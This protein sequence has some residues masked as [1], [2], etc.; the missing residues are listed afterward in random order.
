M[1]CAKLS[2]DWN[3]SFSLKCFFLVFFI[4]FGLHFPTPLGTRFPG[5]Q[6]PQWLMAPGWTGGDYNITLILLWSGAICIELIEWLVHQVNT[7]EPLTQER[8]GM[9]H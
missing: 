3:H 8:P 2:P 9:S 4:I 6:Q 5:H 1:V 7:D